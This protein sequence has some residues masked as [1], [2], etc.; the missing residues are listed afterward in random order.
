M[1]ATKS[2]TI[3]QTKPVKKTLRL[4]PKQ[5]NETITTD[6]KRTKIRS[7]R[8]VVVSREGKKYHYKMPS[9]AA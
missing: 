5:F 3:L 6:K 9:A 1:S 2:I 4:S 7:G 8:R